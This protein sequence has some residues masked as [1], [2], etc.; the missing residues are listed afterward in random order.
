MVKYAALRYNSSTP[1][2]TTDSALVRRSIWSLTKRGCKPS[3]L[4]GVLIT[5]PPVTSV[6]VMVALR[7]GAYASDSVSNATGVTFGDVFKAATEI[8]AGMIP[9][10]SSRG[11]C[12]SFDSRVLVLSA[13]ARDAAERAGELTS[14]DDP[15]RLVLKDGEYVLREG[16]FEFV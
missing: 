12:I 9:Y 15:T 2:H 10:V 16:G 13:E 6:E 5:Q 3:G 11:C 14:E 1:L 8:A 4:D 7:P